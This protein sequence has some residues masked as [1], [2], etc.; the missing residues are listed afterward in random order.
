MNLVILFVFICIFSLIIC[1]IYSKTSDNNKSTFVFS[2][3]SS[4]GG[5]GGKGGKGG[6]GGG[7]GGGRGGGGK[8]GGRS[9]AGPKG[10]D[11]GLP[12]NGGGGEPPPSGGDPPK[13]SQCGIPVTS[14]DQLDSI[15][16]AIGFKFNLKEQVPIQN[17][18]RLPER[19]PARN[20]PLPLP[21]EPHQ[22]NSEN[23][24]LDNLLK[25]MM[26]N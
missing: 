7:G 6:R 1:E 3:P 25:G 22:L 4:G 19:V 2:R 24:R 23:T 16:K 11:G 26:N 15:F 12:P 21:P 13:D 18:P 5:K 20:G 8:K 14:I 17:L 10:P 9:G